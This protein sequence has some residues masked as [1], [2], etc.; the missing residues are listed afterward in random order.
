MTYD[1][2]LTEVERPMDTARALRDALPMHFS[3]Y[4]AKRITEEICNEGGG[5]VCLIENCTPETARWVVET[6]TSVDGTTV[7]V[8]PPLPF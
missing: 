5:Y 4:D 2:Y 3:F 1:I 7:E 6:L 8:V